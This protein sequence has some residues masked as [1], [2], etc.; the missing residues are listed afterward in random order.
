MVVQPKRLDGASMRSSDATVICLQWAKRKR[1]LVTHPVRHRTCAAGRR[2]IRRSDAV[3]DERGSYFP[4][5][6][7]HFGR[8]QVLDVPVSG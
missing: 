6:P 8:L 7:R 5:T 1:K 2:G 4:I 3:L